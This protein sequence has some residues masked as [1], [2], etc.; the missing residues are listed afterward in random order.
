[1]QSSLERIDPERMAPGEATGQDTL[2]LHLER[3]EYA[4]RFL[5]RG[6]CADIACGIGYGSLLLATRYGDLVDRIIAVD[7]DKESIETARVRYHH[8]QIE[9]RIGDALTFTS[10]FPLQTVIS[11][12]TIEHLHDPRTF[13]HNIATQLDSGARFIASV[14]ITPSMDAN[15]YHLHDFSPAAFVK[16]FE[17]AGF[18]MI[19]SFLQVQPYRLFSVLG[20]KESRSKDLR[21]NICA[22]YV[23]HPSK[24]FLRLRSLLT[25]GFHNKYL[26]GVFEKL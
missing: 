19:D 26:V 17:N 3:Y 15:P 8:P 11:L 23:A 10:P 5:Q 24:F 13:I 18:R 12:E 6:N 4:A 25:D 22:Y 20:K 7:V 16:M 14:P 1:M 2:R 9:F 21:K